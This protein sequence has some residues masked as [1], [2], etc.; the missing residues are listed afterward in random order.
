M[1]D[2]RPDSPDNA[3]TSTI[4]VTDLTDRVC[5]YKIGGIVGE[6]NISYTLYSYSNTDI[7]VDA[8]SSGHRR[9]IG[10]I[11]GHM[12]GNAATREESQ[13]FASIN[14]GNITINNKTNLLYF[15]I[16]PSLNSLKQFLKFY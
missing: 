3:V 12:T 1:H 14:L 4:N 15:I 9:H 16:N 8:S 11:V 2:F 6:S 13:L 7:T 10:G 5:L